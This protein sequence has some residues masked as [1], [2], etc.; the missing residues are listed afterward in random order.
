MR[1]QNKGGIRIEKATFWN[2]DHGIG[3]HRLRANDGRGSY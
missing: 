2:D 1:E 3:N